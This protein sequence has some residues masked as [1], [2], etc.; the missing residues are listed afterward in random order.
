MINQLDITQIDGHFLHEWNE[1]GEPRVI[2]NYRDPRDMILSAVNFYS[3]K[4]GHGISN[5]NDIQVFSDILRSKETLEDQLEYA[6]TDPSFPTMSGH[7]R[8]LWLFNHPNVCKTSFEDLVG[9]RGGGSAEAQADAIG[10][11]MEF[12]GITGKK[13]R[14]VAEQLFNPDAFSFYR[15][16]TGAWREV[17]TPALRRL[18]DDRFGEVL[19]IY[20][21]Q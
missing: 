3:G 9:P 2:Y 21:Y 1:T 6:L 5:Y 12:L 17:F 13:P 16:Q 20:G 15:G 19:R 7:E 18:A 14:D 11:V 8:M 4:T 10:R